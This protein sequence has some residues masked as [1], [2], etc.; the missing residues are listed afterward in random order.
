MIHGHYK[1]K[2]VLH[3][4]FTH[5]SLG[6]MQDGPNGEIFRITAL[7]QKKPLSLNVV[8][9]AKGPS[10]DEAKIFVG[11]MLDLQKLP[12]LVII[13]K[14]HRSELRLGTDA[15]LYNQSVNAE[16]KFWYNENEIR[17]TSPFNDPSVPSGEIAVD[18]YVADCSHVAPFTYGE[19]RND[20]S[21]VSPE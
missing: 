9:V 8:A 2:L 11:H 15:I 20:M 16:F 1:A 6:F 17:S 18:I 19:G 14:G 4:I 13:N 7:V 3:N 10:G 12:M 5:V 21:N